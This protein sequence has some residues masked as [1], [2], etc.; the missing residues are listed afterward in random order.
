MHNFDSR[1]KETVQ[2][3]RQVPTRDESAPLGFAT[4]VSAR[5]ALST[6]RLS[7]EQI[8]RRL[9]F[10]TLATLAVVLAACAV[11]EAP[12]LRERSPFNP[13]VENTVAQLLDRL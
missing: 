4:R 3:A 9:S 8:W 2:V 7:I 12:Y 5:V 6:Q 13:N 10:G 11:L 1:W